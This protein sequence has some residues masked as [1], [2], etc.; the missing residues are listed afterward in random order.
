MNLNKSNIKKI[1][2]I[3]TDHL[4]DLILTLPAIRSV[5]LNFP[6]S[7]LCV[8]IDQRYNSLIKNCGYVDKII[9]VEDNSLIK[10]ILAL[11]NEKFD[12]IIDL[13]CK[14]N[15]KISLAMF[16]SSARYKVGYLTHKF[17]NLLLN[18]C[19]T[20]PKEILYELDYCLNV[21]KAIG[22]EK[23][24]KDLLL[25]FDKDSVNKIDEELKSLSKNKL[26]VGIT[27]FVDIEQK[28]WSLEKYGELINKIVEEKNVE[29]IIPYSENDEF[30]VQCLRNDVDKKTIFLKTNLQ[31]LYYLI[32]KCDLLITN[33]SGPMHLGLA[34]KISTIVINGP[35]I[36]QRWCHPKYHVVVSKHLGCERDCSY[37][38]KNIDFKCIKDISVDE[39]YKAAS[40]KIKMLRVD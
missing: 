10:L 19:I 25:P 14:S 15:P 32:S 18:Y 3:R 31:E 28:Q 11:R 13:A 33:N 29:V 36:I 38:W 2:L 20:P 12:L 26:L 23:I 17:R 39:V 27:P 24:S 37:C 22:L 34:A 1:L 21:L 4:G 6:D 7:E 16:F 9:N 40:N 30:K 35:S 8:L 5:K